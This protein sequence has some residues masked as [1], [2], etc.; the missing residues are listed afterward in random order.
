MIGC[1]WFLRRSQL[2]TSTYIVSTLLWVV[3]I[4]YVMN[5]VLHRFCRQKRMRTRKMDLL[6]TN[7]INANLE[8]GLLPLEH[9]GTLEFRRS[10]ERR[11]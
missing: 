11:E 10:V 3:V 9:L 5:V 2:T 7:I 4:Y 8:K 6:G 1:D